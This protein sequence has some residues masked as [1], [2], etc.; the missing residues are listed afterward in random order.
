MK[1]HTHTTPCDKNEVLFNAGSLSFVNSSVPFGILSV[2][3]KQKLAPN[4]II[5]EVFTTTILIQYSALRGT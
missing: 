2:L 5:P 1:I 3:R 4:N